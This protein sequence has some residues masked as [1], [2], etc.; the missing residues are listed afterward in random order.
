M[1]FRKKQ[2]AAIPRV[3]HYIWL[4]PKPMPDK[5]AAFMRGWRDRHPGWTLQRWDETNLPRLENQ[6]CFDEHPFLSGK[7]NLLRYEILRAH[8]GVYIDTD[9]ECVKNIEPLLSDVTCFAAWQNAT[10]INNAILGAVAGHPLWDDL[11]R[12]IPD[13]VE[14]NRHL[15]SPFQTGPHFMTPI[16]RER[17]P[18]VTLFPSAWFYP[19]PWQEAHREP[20]ASEFPRAYAIHRWTLSA[21]ALPSASV[22]LASRGDVLRLEWVLEGLCAQDVSDFDVLVVSRGDPSAEPSLRTLVLRYARRLTIR[23][24]ALDTP[25]NGFHADTAR[26]VGLRET[27]GACVLFLED[28]SVPDPDWVREHRLAHLDDKA[29]AVSQARRVP[30]NAITAFEGTLDYPALWA[31]ARPEPAADTH[32]ASPFPGW[33]GSC[34]APRILLERAC[35]FDPLLEAGDAEDRELAQRMQC[36]EATVKRLGR[37][38][39]TRLEIAVTEPAPIDQ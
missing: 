25:G 7:A 23:H 36:A 34:S 22:V 38:R 11:I 15:P 28:D 18:D 6:K 14:H 35:R 21:A 19:Y 9:F 1:L 27:C 37:G 33:A 5:W 10:T 17:H 13:S 26:R 20:D 8:G 12:N 24:R 3:F 31:S 39:V 29:V 30:S 32:A 2:A 4:G 16:L